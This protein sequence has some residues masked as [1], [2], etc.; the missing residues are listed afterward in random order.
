MQSVARPV[1]TITLALFLAA[2]GSQDDPSLAKRFP[3]G[4]Q[5]ESEGLLLRPESERFLDFFIIG[6]EA[7][8]AQFYLLPPLE[9]NPGA[10]DSEF[11]ELQR[12]LYW[13]NF[14][15]SHGAIMRRLPPNS[16]VFVGVP[17]SL[18]SAPQGIEREYFT[19]Y[20]KSHCYWSDADI[21]RRL[22]FFKTP[23]PLVWMQDAGEILGRDEK[24]R[25][26][27]RIDSKGR[28]EYQGN[29]RSLVKSYPQYFQLKETSAHVHA[30]GGDE[31]MV[32]MPDG[33]LG[34][35][36]GRNRVTEYMVSTRGEASRSAA[37]SR[38]T[39]EEIYR[40]FSAAFYKL[41][42]FF[43][44]EGALLDP[45]KANA[46][47]FHVDMMVTVL[48]NHLGT[49]AFVPSFTK[50][51]SDAGSWEPLDAAKVK[52]WQREFDL[53]AKQ[54]DTLGYIVR[55]LP[56]DDHPARSPANVIK[57]FDVDSERHTVFLGRYPAHGPAGT[58]HAQKRLRDA[59]WSFEDATAR[60]MENPAPESLAKTRDKL[61]RVWQQMDL[62][63]QEP[64]PTFEAQAE[65]F[66]KEGYAVIPVSVFPWGSGGLHCMVLQ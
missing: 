23:T 64:N 4:V 11:K 22:H 65:V 14:E 6:L 37:I 28:P 38:A 58:E 24:G 52:S 15:L 29:I 31:E 53:C 10:S 54:M 56:L 47:L 40:D 20:L 61:A 41:P 48:R 63:S 49:H 26:V 5:I 57:Y 36:I 43:V 33:E 19:A 62:T 34:M 18:G 42:V 35:M 13:L 21:K 51:P 17:D 39:L 9:K 45:S 1:F 2:C 60:W 50:K 59:L 32:W 46:E 3:K 7:Y 55:R 66:R 44:P 27:I 12:E 25:A 8:K 16:R 30:E